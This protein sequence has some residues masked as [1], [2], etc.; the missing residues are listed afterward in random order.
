[1]PE[2]KIVEEWYYPDD[3]DSGEV[4][5]NPTEKAVGYTKCVTGEPILING[6]ISKKSFEKITGGES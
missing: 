4:A 6:Y 1:M 5:R 2:K 3:M